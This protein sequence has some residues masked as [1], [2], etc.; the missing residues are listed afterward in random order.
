MPAV[1]STSHRRIRGIKHRLEHLMRHHGLR[2]VKNN[3]KA[4]EA[5]LSR[6]EIRETN[7]FNS[8]KSK[9]HFSPRIGGENQNFEGL[10]LGQWARKYMLGLG[11]VQGV[12]VVRG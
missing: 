1:G 9:P 7:G 11:L 2:S 4:S 6:V 12:S 10:L 3:Y 5:M 8:P